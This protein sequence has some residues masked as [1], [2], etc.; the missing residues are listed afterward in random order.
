M[1]GVYFVIKFDHPYSF[2]LSRKGSI[3][4]ELFFGPVSKPLIHD[5][6]QTVQVI[7][8]LLVSLV[9]LPPLLPV[10]NYSTLQFG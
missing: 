2:S 8:T 3:I 6:S 5:H 7:F 10:F 4:P 1:P 9:S